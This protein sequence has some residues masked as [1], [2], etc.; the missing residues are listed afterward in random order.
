M[1][2]AQVFINFDGNMM[3]TRTFGNIHAAVGNFDSIFSQI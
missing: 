3:I 1:T 2:Q